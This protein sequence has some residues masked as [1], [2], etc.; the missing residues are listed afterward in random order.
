VWDIQTTSL[1]T[2]V[3]ASVTE[4]ALLNILH[5]LSIAELYV[6][7]VLIYCALLRGSG[8]RIA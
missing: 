6:A 2:F 3:P 8:G 4:V 1:D 5:R 7:S